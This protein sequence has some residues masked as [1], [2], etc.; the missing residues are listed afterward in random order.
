M[1]FSC[2]HEIRKLAYKKALGEAGKKARENTYP[3]E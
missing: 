2:L 3:S 1:K